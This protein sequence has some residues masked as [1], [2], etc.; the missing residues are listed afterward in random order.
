LLLCMAAKEE[1]CLLKVPVNPS[2]L[3][4]SHSSSEKCATLP[5]ES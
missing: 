5:V 4:E 3:I 2:H 1:A